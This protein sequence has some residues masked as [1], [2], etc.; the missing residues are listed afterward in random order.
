LLDVAA[1]TAKGDGLVIPIRSIAVRSAGPVQ[2]CHPTMVFATRGHRA[3]FLSKG[4]WKDASR[5]PASKRDN[6]ATFLVSVIVSIV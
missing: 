1:E 4:L 5:S 6:A 3:H 2:F